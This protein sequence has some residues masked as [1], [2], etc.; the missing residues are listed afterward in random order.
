MTSASLLTANLRA[1]SNGNGSQFSGQS[2]WLALSRTLPTRSKT[3]S[4]KLTGQISIS[5]SPEVL[6]TQKGRLL[7]RLGRSGPRASMSRLRASKTSLA[8]YSPPTEEG[9]TSIFGSSHLDRPRSPC[10]SRSFA[11]SSRPEAATV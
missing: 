8:S 3:M 6:A 5:G 2:P 4:S 9:L 10:T 7:H 11:T 1:T